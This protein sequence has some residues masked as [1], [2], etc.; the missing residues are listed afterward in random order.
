MYPR[1]PI[2]VP[3]S[4]QRLFPGPQFLWQ[5]R[6]SASEVHILLST[7]PRWSLASF[8]LPEDHLSW[9][10]Q[11]ILSSLFEIT[12]SRNVMVSSTGKQG[13]ARWF[14]FTLFTRRPAL[15]FNACLCHQLF[16]TIFK[17]VTSSRCVRVGFMDSLTSQDARS[18]YGYHI[19]W[20][21]WENTLGVTC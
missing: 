16:V 11:Q 10:G 18:P 2:P 3:C 21:N 8:R 5:H 12:L 7:E 20:W 1:V 14:C 19:D 15:T 9:L 13:F 6:H 4:V 17:L